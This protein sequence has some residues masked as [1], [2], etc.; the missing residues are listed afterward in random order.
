ME[1]A[2]AAGTGVAEPL[3]EGVLV[4]VNSAESLGHESRSNMNFNFQ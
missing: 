2:S 1:V 4:A 3:G